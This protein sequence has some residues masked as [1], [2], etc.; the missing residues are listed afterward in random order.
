MA[1]LQTPTDGSRL[2]SEYNQETLQ[3]DTEDWKEHQGDG[4]RGTFKSSSLRKFS[5]GTIGFPANHKI[6]E[7]ICNFG[8]LVF[9]CASTTLQQPN[10]LQPWAA[11][12]E[13]EFTD[14]G[15]GVFSFTS[16]NS[17]MNFFVYTYMQPDSNNMALL[18]AYSI[19]GTLQGSFQRPGDDCVGVAMLTSTRFVV[20]TKT[21]HAYVTIDAQVSNLGVVA[22][23][24][25]NGRTYVMSHSEASS[26]IILE[27]ANTDFVY[28]GQVAP[29]NWLLRV[30]FSVNKF[31][32]A[33]N[34]NN[35][36]RVFNDDVAGFFTMNSL[37]SIDGNTLLV[38][39][40]T[41]VWNNYYSVLTKSNLAQVVNHAPSNMTVASK[42][43]PLDTTSMY[44]SFEDNTV[45]KLVIYS[46]VVTRTITLPEIQ[47][48][49]SRPSQFSFLVTGSLS[50]SKYIR[51]ID[52]SNFAN[53]LSLVVSGS[54]A[55]NS[56]ALGELLYG[57]NQTLSFINKDLKRL[58]VVL[59]AEDYCIIP[60]KLTCTTCGSGRYLTSNSSDY[61]CLLPSQFPIGYGND[62]TYMQPC[63]G[64]LTS[65]CTSCP[66][67]YLTC[68]ACNTAS[69]YYLYA[70]LSIC[71]TVSTMP[72]TLGVNNGASPK[73]VTS[74]SDSNC[75]KCA[76]D[77]TQC[78][79]CK[80]SWYLKNPTDGKC[81]QNNIETWG[82]LSQSPF[83]EIKKCSDKNCKWC[84][85][86]FSACTECKS[87][88]YFT[89]IAGNP[90]NTNT[91]IG[92]GFQSVG[93]DA[94]LLASCSDT[95]CLECFTDHTFCTKCKSPHLLDADDLVCKLSESRKG[96]DSSGIYL[97]NCTDPH[98]QQCTIHNAQC[99]VCDPSYYFMF[100]DSS[101]CV[102]NDRAGFGLVRLGLTTSVISP[103]LDTNC[104]W[105]LEETRICTACIENYYQVVGQEFVHPSCFTN[106]Q[107]KR[108]LNTDVP[109]KLDDCTVLGCEVCFSWNQGCDQC[110]P[111]LYVLETSSPVVCEKNDKIQRGLKTV[112]NRTQPLLSNCSLN[113]CK[114]CFLDYQECRA[115]LDGFVLNTSLGSCVPNNLE[116]Q[117]Q[118]FKTGGWV[119]QAKCQEAFCVDCFQNIKICNRCDATKYYQLKSG[120]CQLDQPASSSLDYLK[121]IYFDKSTNRFSILFSAPIHPIPNLQEQVAYQLV[122]LETGLALGK[123]LYSVS[124]AQES[125]TKISAQ[126]YVSNSE[127]IGPSVM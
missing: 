76:S 2:R 113:E 62:T 55:D 45:R 13:S 109:A 3:R 51:V 103:C 61:E 102:Q 19:N 33:G 65:G 10:L 127:S 89:Q 114:D 123:G 101:K 54:P 84:L 98:C 94:V 37:E 17:V 70:Q 120:R 14:S 71:Y 86:N 49:L 87:N 97:R 73:V 75:L 26:T 5:K 117:G 74:C 122:S 16:T 36:L 7:V 77:H 82:I 112:A 64:S 93:G 15:R 22:F 59:L 92:F 32:T 52:L 53:T 85:A 63:L 42:V 124:F 88:T 29:A 108:G 23:T 24:L 81:Y 1:P 110:E 47:N 68:V 83:G 40:S 44:M 12:V 35:A 80:P 21:T 121:P 39:G 34:S 91:L 66:T 69:G 67:T 107:T 8:L 58:D 28:I 111:G 106:N 72:D 125:S 104:M 43:E 25:N 18:R 78:T 95:N 31:S 50:P 99:Q 79:Q 56:L 38:A 48:S 57:R 116:G 30:H 11:A 100:N 41:Q 105:C 6:K 126:V 118:E 90:C 60:F 96:R 115:C 9:W 27:E 4:K 20:A 119:V 46:A